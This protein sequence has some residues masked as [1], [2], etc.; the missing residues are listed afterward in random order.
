MTYR[1]L[2]SDGLSEEGLERLRQGAEVWAQPRISAADLVQALP[3][4]DALV[5]RSRTK[6]T[7]RLLEAGRRLIFLVCDSS[8]K[9]VPA[10]MFVLTSRALA[11]AAS[12]AIGRLDIG[13][14]V[15]NSALARTNDALAFTTMFIGS[16]DLTT[17]LLT[18]SDRKS[19]RLNSSH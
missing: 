4:F 8:G 15:A 17:G 2:V 3:D 7:A 10:A 16:L 6:V 1:I 14:Q 9:G 19:T 18:Y 12:A 11:V 5:V 13:L